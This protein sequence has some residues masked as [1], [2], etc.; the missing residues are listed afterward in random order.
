MK[1]YNSLTRQIEE[2]QPAQAG[3]VTMYSCGPTV[4]DHIH[5]GNLSSFIFADMLRRVLDSSGLK[6]LHAMNFTDVDDKTIKRSLEQYADLDPMAALLRLTGEYSGIFMQDMAA[7]G[8]DVGAMAFIKATDSIEPMQQ[9]IRELHALGF[10]YIADDGVYFSISNYQKAGKK[11]GQLTDVTVSSTSQ[12]RIQ[13]D[14]YDKES[15]HDF[16]LWKK[17]KNNEP[18]WNFELNNQAIAGRPGWHIECSAMS[19]LLLGQPFDIHTGGVDLK[20]PH[21]E[22]EIAQSTAGKDTKYARVFAHNEHLLI[23]GQKMSKSL[24]NFYALSVIEDKGF[25]PLAFRLL[26]LQAH[27]RKQAHFSWKNLEAAQNRL[28]GYRAMADLY[29]QTRQQGGLSEQNLKQHIQA[30]STA[31]QDDLDTPAALA[32]LSALEAALDNDGISMSCQEAYGKALEWLDNALGLQLLQENI[33]D[34][35]KELIAKREQARAD[36]DWTQSDKLREQL[37]KQGLMVRDSEAGTI[38]HRL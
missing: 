26:V 33:T 35:Q 27:Y 13:N 19:R 18:A 37:R 25:D 24:G 23:D 2:L 28:D 12:A 30:I 3:T 21:H 4:Y 22:N 31:L 14:E 6:V 10:A 20:F 11:Y 34:S 5:I 16:A 38:W 8:N 29:W 9:L 7:V 17:A 15:A 36:Q 32:A 1:L